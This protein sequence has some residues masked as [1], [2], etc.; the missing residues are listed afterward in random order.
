VFADQG[1]EAGGLLSADVRG[2]T[3]VVLAQG[4]YPLSVVLSAGT[5][6]S[7][8]LGAFPSGNILHK[9]V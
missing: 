8:G 2:C 6:A 9:N 1:A 5:L 7:F 3:L 4:R